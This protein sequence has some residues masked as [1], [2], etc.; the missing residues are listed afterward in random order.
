MTVT[1]GRRRR[2]PVPP[3]RSCCRSANPAESSGLAQTALKINSSLGGA[4]T[5]PSGRWLHPPKAHGVGPAFGGTARPG[6]STIRRR[7]EQTS[8]RLPGDA[9]AS[10]RRARFTSLVLRAWRRAA[11]AQREFRGFRR[12]PRVEAQ[13]ARGAMGSALDRGRIAAAVIRFVHGA[14][15]ARPL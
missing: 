7:P 11:Y 6:A 2:V 9:T 10:V 3:G 5:L 13:L 4:R 15:A 8:P 1:V 14:L 12:S